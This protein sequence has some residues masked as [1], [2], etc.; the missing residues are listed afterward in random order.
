MLR[1]DSVECEEWS[2]ELVV[3]KTPHSTLIELAR[4]EFYAAKLFSGQEIGGTG[5]RYND[6]K[7]TYQIAI[8]V[9]GRLVQDEEFYHS[10]E[11][12]DPIRGVSLNGRSRIITLELSK[13][14]DIVDKPIDKMSSQER[15]GI[16]F[17]FL[18]DKSKRSE[19]NK[20]LE[21]EE[22]IAMASKI[23]KSISKDEIERA[24]L[25][26]ELKYQLDTQSQLTD[27]K[28]E[29]RHEAEQEIID[30]LES[31]KSPEEIL[32]ALKRGTK[33]NKNRSEREK[34]ESKKG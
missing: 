8:L 6:L 27:A 26:S 25:M 10:F 7:Q 22:G 2:V 16:F 32:K 29:G 28:L 23:L 4:L 30:L 11:N 5:K 1:N 18:T 15:W 9:N 24:L 12:Y 21:I 31:G 34:Q 20:I 19:I 14:K 3:A 17:K 33:T 13:L